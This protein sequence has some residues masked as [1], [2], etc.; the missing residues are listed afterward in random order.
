MS[1][2]YIT[3]NQAK[4]QLNIDLGLTVDDDKITDLI[5]AAID[6]AENDT[7]RSLSELLELNSPDDSK[8]VPVADPKSLWPE[9]CPSNSHVWDFY[10]LRWVDTASWMQSD[11]RAFWAT[12]PQYQPGF[13]QRDDALPLRRDVKNALLMWI[14]SRYD[15]N[16]ENF[17]MLQTAAEQQLWPYRKALGV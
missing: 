9:G 15:K 13:E 12:N 10:G 14:E 8:A 4:A 16:P 1:L 11:Y 5:G 17:L 6:W 2:D 7:N 3:L